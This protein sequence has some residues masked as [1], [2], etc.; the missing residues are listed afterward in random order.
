LSQSG[1]GNFTRK[2]FQE[3]YDEGGWKE[4]RHY[5]KTVSTIQFNQ[6]KDG[7]HGALKL[8]MINSIQDREHIIAHKSDMDGVAAWYCI[9]EQFKNDNN[10]KHKIQSIK[11]QCN[12][13]YTDRYPGGIFE[14]PKHSG[15]TL[16]NDG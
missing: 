15:N 1:Q 13:E 4:A 2:K 11:S 10:I 7:I 16:L 14:F 8:A 5:A 12:V 3:T 6:D 9:N